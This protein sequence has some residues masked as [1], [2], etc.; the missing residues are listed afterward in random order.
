MSKKYTAVCGESWTAGSAHAL[1]RIQRFKQRDGE[2]LMEALKREG[3]EDASFV[4]SGWPKLHL[5]FDDKASARVQARDRRVVCAALRASDGSILCGARHFDAL[6]RAQI[7][8]CG[9]ENA[10]KWKKPDQGFIDQHGVFL[11]AKRPSR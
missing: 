5:D 2:T 9:P 1:P 4:F 8:A 3:M 10:N 11:P 7:E 6:M